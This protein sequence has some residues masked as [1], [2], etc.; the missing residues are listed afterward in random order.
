MSDLFDQDDVEWPEP[1]ED[2][3]EEPSESKAN[4]GTPGAVEE[5]DDS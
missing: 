1:A 4:D 5:D 2:P 3:E